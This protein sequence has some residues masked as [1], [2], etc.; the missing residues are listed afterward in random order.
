TGQPWVCDTVQLLFSGTKGLVAG[1][2]LLLVQRD[3]L[4]LDAP[5]SQYWPEFGVESKKGV[6]VRD[7]VSHT[8]R[9]PGLDTQ[10]SWRSATEGSLI[11]AL[12]AAQPLSRDGR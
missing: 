4:D 12:I 1:C 7:V 2:L 11:A 10:V 5:V 3:L 6:L 9:L 8:A